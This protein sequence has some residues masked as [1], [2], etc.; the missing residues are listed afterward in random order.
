MGLIYKGDG[1][2]HILGVPARDLTDDEVQAIAR[3]WGYSL[4]ETEGLLIKHKLYM[5]APKASPKTASKKE[6]EG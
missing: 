5:V 3:E 1:N 6:S 4:A 2:Q